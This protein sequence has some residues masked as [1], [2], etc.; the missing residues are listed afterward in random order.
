MYR[1]V[2]KLMETVSIGEADPRFGK[3]LLEQFGR[4]DGELVAGM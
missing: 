1:H 2:K 4:A 3:I